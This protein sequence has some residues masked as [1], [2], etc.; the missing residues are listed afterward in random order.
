MAWSGRFGARR[1]GLSCLE[2]AQ[3][4][5]APEAPRRQTQR[6]E[7]MEHCKLRC[8]G[9]MCGGKWALRQRGLGLGVPICVLAGEHNSPPTASCRAMA[10]SG[11]APQGYAVQCSCRGPDDDAAA[12]TQSVIL[13]AR[14]SQG[15]CR[16]SSN[17]RPTPLIR[18]M[19]RCCA[20]AART[21]SWSRASRPPA[22]TR[23]AA[24]VSQAATRCVRR[25]APACSWRTPRLISRWPASLTTCSSI[26]GTPCLAR[27]RG[28][29]ASRLSTRWCR[30]GGSCRRGSAGSVRLHA[31]GAARSARRA[32]AAVQLRAGG[33]SVQRGLR[34]GAAARPGPPRG[35]MPISA[36]AT[37][38][39]GR[40]APQ[41]G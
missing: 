5:S 36:A 11:T 32:R 9:G 6:A 16:K 4:P 21:C 18:C 10:A 20:A 26:A 41:H 7:K 2:A 28:A 39:A 22:D 19:Q 35:H 14:P 38:G 12:R 33:V 3:R 37:D 34:P 13:V 29:S 25:T 23:S 40:T 15:H 27:V 8:A 30:R 31:G 1:N 24:R 17:A